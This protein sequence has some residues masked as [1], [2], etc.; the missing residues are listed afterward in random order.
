MM[1]PEE[2]ALKF[3]QR[4]GY[5]LV[6]FAEV[7]LP[8]FR[9]GL[10]VVALDRKPLLPIEEFVLKSV[11]AGLDTI[12][13]VASLLGMTQSVIEGAA[14]NLIVSEHLTLGGSPGQS[15]QRLGLTTKGNRALVDAEEI[16][17]SDVS[18][19]V[20]FDRVT[21]QME[22]Y[23]PTYL[24]RP[25]QARSMGLVDLAPPLARRAELRDL[26]LEELNS[27]LHGSTRPVDMRRDV[28]AIKSVDRAER[29]YLPAVALVYRST[30]S[31]D[32]N[33]A[34]VIDGKLSDKHE[35]AFALSGGPQ[36][37][38]IA[39]SVLSC[40]SEVG[41]DEVIEL[42][43]LSHLGD[44]SGTTA[45]RDGIGVAYLDLAEAERASRSAE[46]QEERS[47]AEADLAER[48][49]KLEEEVRA[50]ICGQVMY[51]AVHEHPPLLRSALESARKRLMI[52]S[53]WIRAK[54]VDRTFLSGIERLL[55]SGV[56]V[57]IGYGLG[58]VAQEKRSEEDRRAEKNLAD[59]AEKYNNFTMKRMGDTHAK[60][61]IK[62]QEYAVVTSF[63]WLSFKGDPARTFR[64]E[65]GVLIGI[66]EKV[67]EKFDEQLA[68]FE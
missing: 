20:E 40:K 7:S 31:D 41:A 4:P 23:A 22:L 16:V 10:T 19:S 21:W 42:E 26:K 67:D 25:R 52:V 12:E 38:G 50:L 24:V 46:T 58:D 39:Q 48:E 54:V 63:N 29:F 9:L 13:D 6:S 27:L 59:L 34:F 60:I 64:E 45:N 8:V 5:R 68:R 3:A 18:V 55:S 65:Q 36:K 35:K 47:F 53:P 57:Y 2:I 14:S 32:V 66:A 11:G 33:V 37:S 56:S 51:V 49:N 1:L 62:D 30:G 17:A 44:R 28:L 15:E 61:L 43:L